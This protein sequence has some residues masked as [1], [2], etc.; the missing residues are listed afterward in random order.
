MNYYTIG[1]EPIQV[2]AIDNYID[3]TRLSE[4]LNVKISNWRASVGFLSRLQKIQ[5][6]TKLDETQLYQARKRFPTFMHPKLALDLVNYAKFS[7][8]RDEAREFLKNLLHN[9]SED[10]NFSVSCCFKATKCSL[11]T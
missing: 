11:L 3:G 4:I 7:N 9:E 1:N 10:V 2:R 6:K 5:D 8:K